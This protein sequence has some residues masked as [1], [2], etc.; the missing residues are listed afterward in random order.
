VRGREIEEVTTVTAYQRREWLVA[1]GTSG[2]WGSLNRRTTRG[3]RHSQLMRRDHGCVG[4]HCGSGQWRARAR[5]VRHAMRGQA[6][7]GDLEDHVAAVGFV[8]GGCPRDKGGP[9]RSSGQ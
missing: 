9:C 8:P 2:S 5:Q 6:Q 4:Q 3:L 1:G 7:V